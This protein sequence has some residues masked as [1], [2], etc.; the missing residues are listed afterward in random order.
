VSYGDITEE[1][2]KFIAEHINSVEQLEVLL[3][4]HS[5]TS[6]EFSAA[7]LSRE[8]RIDPGSA[9]TRLADLHFHGFL[10]VNGSE[11]PLYRY[12][13]KLSDQDRAVNSISQTYLKHR[14]TVI[15]LIF[16]KP[17][18]KIRTFADAFKFKKEE[19]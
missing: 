1:D 10:S 12:N 4:L 16:S 3:F 8:L 13:P 19:D 15:N 7:D 5:N 9:A 18:D 6:K 14:Y 2:K 17:I 11:P